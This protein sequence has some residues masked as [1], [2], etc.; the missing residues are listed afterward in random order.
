MRPGGTRRGGVGGGLAM[1]YTGGGMVVRD[2]ERCRCE[3]GVV[4]LLL[5]V[6]PERELL[7]MASGRLAGLQR[8]GGG[9]GRGGGGGGGA[10]GRVGAGG[11]PEVVKERG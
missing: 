4:N 7:A 5:R 3:L 1:G 2:G 10:G 6:R 9:G 11:E 8:G